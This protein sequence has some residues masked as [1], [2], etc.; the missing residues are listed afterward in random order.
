[1]G[2]M[3]LLAMDLKRLGLLGFWTMF[4]IQNSKEHNISE[5]GSLSIFTC[6]GRHL[7]YWVRYKQLTSIIG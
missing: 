5:N 6:R 1:V 2:A 3:V 7:L 4:T